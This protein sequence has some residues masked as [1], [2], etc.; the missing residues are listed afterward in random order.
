MYSKNIFIKTKSDEI[1]KNNDS[2]LTIYLQKRIFKIASKVVS[3]V[4]S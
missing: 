2:I 1:S 3:G 4:L